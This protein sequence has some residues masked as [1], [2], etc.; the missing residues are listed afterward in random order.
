MKF[1]Q[2]LPNCKLSNKNVNGF[3]IFKGY[4]IFIYIFLTNYCTGIRIVGV[5]PEPEP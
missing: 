3:K 2:H 1:L 5:K 4:C